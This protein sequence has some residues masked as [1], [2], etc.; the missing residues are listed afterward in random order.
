V[1]VSLSVAEWAQR[2]MKG[3]AYRLSHVAHK[4]DRRG[5]S[6]IWLELC[7]YPD[8][9]IQ[10]VVFH[11]TID[12]GPQTWT[13]HPKLVQKNVRYYYDIDG[14]L[15]AHVRGERLVYTFVYKFSEEG[16]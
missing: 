7:F 3:F 8:G 11:A 1:S 5:L 9:V 2:Y 12:R 14:K 15:Y 10:R 4:Q 16:S 6:G 13:S